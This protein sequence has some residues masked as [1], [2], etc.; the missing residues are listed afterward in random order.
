[1]NITLQGSKVT[2]EQVAE[3]VAKHIAALSTGRKELYVCDLHIGHPPDDRL[4]ALTR[5]VE[6][7]CPDKIVCHGDT[8]HK[9]EVDLPDIYKTKDWLTFK[10]LATIIPTYVIPGNHDFDLVAEQIFPA[11]LIQPYLDDYGYWHCHGHEYDPIQQLPRWWQKLWA[12]WFSKTP[13]QLLQPHDG[14]PLYLDACQL[15]HTRIMNERKFK[16]YIFGHTHLPGH[17][18]FPDLNLDMWNGGDFVD[19]FSCIVRT[20]DKLELITL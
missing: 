5:I 3:S 13:Y 17:M 9:N 1:M 12:K 2:E 7:T 8:F 20:D 16:G 14:N 6:K 10:G 11:Q 15:I 18:S 4:M 19:S